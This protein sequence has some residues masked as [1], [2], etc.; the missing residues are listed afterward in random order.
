MRPPEIKAL[1]INHYLNEQLFWQAYSQLLYRV[2]HCSRWLHGLERNYSLTSS[3]LS[4]TSRK[5]FRNCHYIYIGYIDTC[6]LTLPMYTMSQ[7]VWQYWAVLTKKNRWR[8]CYFL[9]QNEFR[10]SSFGVY[11]RGRRLILPQ[12]RTISKGSFK[13]VRHCCRALDLDSDAPQGKVCSKA[14]SS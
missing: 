1:D 10:V 2:L 5:F 12:K 11:S 13:L 9:I 8:I 6:W 3:F 7:R 14:N 4:R